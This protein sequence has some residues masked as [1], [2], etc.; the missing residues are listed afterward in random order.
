M[1][2]TSTCGLA[3][4]RPSQLPALPQL[5]PRMLS[6][7]ATAE[8][9]EAEDGMVREDVR[10]VAIIAH[11]DHGKTTLVDALLQ[12]T[13]SVTTQIGKDDRLMDGNDQEKERGIT[14]LAKNAAVR[15]DGV[16]INIV[17]TPGH[18]DFGGE[19]ERVLGMV[20][21]VLLVVDAAEGPKPQTRFVLKKAIGLGLKVL[22]V[23]NKIDKPH[24]RPDYVIDKTFDLFCELGASDEQTD[25]E[26]V[27]TSAINRQAG[28]DPSEMSDGMGP[29]LDK[30]LDLPKPVASVARP[31]QLQISNVG[32]DQYIGRLLVGR[33]R[34]G[35]LRKGAAI[36]LCAGPGEPVRPVKLTE[37][38][39]HDALGR[40]SVDEASAGD[41]VVAAGISEFNIG[42][43]LVDLAEPHP[44]PPMEIEEP[45]MSITMGV[46]KSPLQGKSGAKLLT[47]AQIQ[48]RLARELEVN[49]ALQ[50]K[51][52][53]SSADQ[54]QV[55]GRGLLHLTVLIEAMRR[56][57]FELMVGPPK[58]LYQAAEDGGKLEPFENVDIDVPD[59]FSGSVIDML[60]LRKGTMLD[61]GAP[62]A[63][64]MVGMQFEVP[65]RGMVGVK[66]R[67]MTATKGLA[68]MTSTFAGYKPTV[69]EF[70]GRERGNLVCSEQGVANTHGL[71]KAQ[72]RG[73][74]F[75]SP[76]DE[77]FEDQIVGIHASAGDLKVNI[78]R[79]KELSNMRAAGKDDKQILSPPKVMTLEDA[80]EYV[81]DGEYVEVTPDAIRMGVLNYQAKGSKKGK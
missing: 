35:S 80:V 78:C 41:I 68:V 19:V 33:I 26:V 45:T 72:A 30:I 70:G 2:G 48:E 77:V 4:R 39:V 63:E 74:L 43:T 42:D 76:G 8:A 36:G 62:S 56:E 67:L 47:L 28:L 21:S 69:G 81:I 64:G 1:V 11:V 54:I 52:D 46:N 75:A 5:L 22:V 44:L 23:L 59:E 10:N 7:E 58:V 60:N 34:S 20:D 24:A 65:T 73:A 14:I 31:L 50:V 53:P 55:Y 57:G 25:F 51:A 29:L 27:Y 38:F 17:D 61:M 66:S 6:S 18:A 32:T 12:A 16:K 71:H 13:Q 9:S 37:I 40:M 15:H 3:A 49:V 79:A